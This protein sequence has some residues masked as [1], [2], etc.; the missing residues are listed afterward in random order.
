[1][2]GEAMG[3]LTNLILGLVHLVLVAADVLFLLLLARMLSYR[4]QPPWLTAVNAACKPVVDWFT[5]CL[6]KGLD[7]LGLK[8]PFERTVLFLGMLAISTA[9]IL[10]VLWLGR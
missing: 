1:M 2:K 10:V 4:W 6:E 5:G 8:A 7:R 3:L 9:R